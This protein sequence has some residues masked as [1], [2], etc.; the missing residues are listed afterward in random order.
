MEIIIQ[1]VGEIS[2]GR[3]SMNLRHVKKECP[4]LR[5]YACEITDDKYLLKDEQGNI[6]CEFDYFILDDNKT[7]KFENF[8]GQFQSEIEKM[9]M[10]KFVEMNAEKTFV[11]EKVK[12]MKLY[13][14][15]EDFWL[16]E[17]KKV[18]KLGTDYEKIIEVELYHVPEE[19]R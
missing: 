4:V 12:K 10:F 19:L 6:V 16:I 7:I 17:K 8:R 1:S 13:Y 3:L 9:L 11:F 5:H 14:S 18:Y 2:A 15:L